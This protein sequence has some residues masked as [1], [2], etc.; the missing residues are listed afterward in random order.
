MGKQGQK[1]PR[2]KPWCRQAVDAVRGDLE[3]ERQSWKQ[4]D[5]RVCLAVWRQYLSVLL[6]K[7]V[8]DIS[9]KQEIQDDDRDVFL[10]YVDA[11]E[12]FEVMERRPG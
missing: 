4:A 10:E 6:S 1:Y 5:V 2:K 11:K 12:L 7:C 9:L 3:I 8:Y